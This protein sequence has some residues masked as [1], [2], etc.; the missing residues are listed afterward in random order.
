MEMLNFKIR[1]ATLSTANIKICIVIK[2]LSVYVYA[3]A[4]ENQQKGPF[5]SK[6]RESI[7]Q[8]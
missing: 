4:L 7:I 2:L 8:V 5:L 1:V 6:E 3:L